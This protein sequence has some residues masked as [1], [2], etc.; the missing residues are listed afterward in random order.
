MIDALLSDR[1]DDRRELFEEA[2]G[3]GLYRDR[4]RSTERSLEQTT[5]DLSRLDDLVNEVTSQVRSLARQRKRA[6]RHARDHHAP[7]RRRAHARVARDGRVDGRA[8]PARRAP[9]GTARARAGRPD[10]GAATPSRRATRRTRRAPPPKRAVMSA[11]GS[12]GD[13][14]G[15]LLTLQ[16]E[17]AVAE[18][19]HRNAA[20]AAHA[21]RAGAQRGGGARRARGRRVRGGARGG[22]TQRGVARRGRGGAAAPR[23]RGGGGARRSGRCARDALERADRAGARDSRPAAPPRA[24]ARGR[25]ARTRRRRAALAHARGASTS[26]SPRSSGSRE[27]DLEVADERLAASRT[28]APPTR[29][30][31]SRRRTTRRAR[32]ATRDAAARADVRRVEEEYTGMQGKLSALEGLERERVGLAPAAARLLRDRER[33]GAGAVLGPLSDFIGADAATALL[34]ERFL[35][36]SVHAVVVRDRARRRRGAPLARARRIRDRC[37]SSR[38]TRTVPAPGDGADGGA[39]SALVQTVGPGARVG[40][41]T[42]RPRARG[43]LGQRVRRRARRGVASGHAVA[44]PARCGAAPSSRSCAPRPPRWTRRARGQPP[45]S[46]RVHAGL[47]AAEA[48]RR[49]GGG[50]RDARTSSRR[51]KRRRCA[52]SASARTCA[53]RANWRTPS[54]SPSASRGRR[55]ELT[56]RVTD[57]HRD[58]GSR[59]R[60]ARRRR[61]R[62]RRRSRAR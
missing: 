31:R 17:I 15:A 9:R 47:E 62:G 33:F 22:G 42:A 60:G 61:A 18:E 57:G 58:A 7:L 30:P 8:R 45:A 1:P 21:R 6:E 48:A 41:R 50:R 52:P 20:R 40:E 54:R 16:G 10:A 55:D 12:L 39:L 25:G 11:T 26:S 56:A 38:S 23:R 34:V 5:A 59:G 29:T 24:R 51:R 3:V 36:P 43:G 53:P 4:R 13:A 14:R 37:C 32:G 49:D 46:R 2:A 28:P 27:R 44:A 35:G 19:R